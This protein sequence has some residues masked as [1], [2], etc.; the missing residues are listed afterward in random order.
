[1]LG[2]AAFLGLRTWHIALRSQPKTYYD[3]RRGR[4]LREILHPHPRHSPRSAHDADA[5][6]RTV[7]RCPSRLVPHR[8]SPRVV[9]VSVVAQ[10]LHPATPITSGRPTTDGS[11]IA[12]PWLSHTQG[13]ID[14]AVHQPS[15]ARAARTPPVPTRARGAIRREE[16][17]AGVGVRW[18]DGRL[19][20][21]SVQFRPRSLG[22]QQLFAL[23]P[24]DAVQERLAGLGRAR[25]ACQTRCEGGVGGL[26]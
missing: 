24:V 12:P 25:R 8:R 11:D 17:Y 2:S 22:R 21:E 5:R 13:G 4:P 14:P 7:H 23:S 1:M 10:Q 18:V 16:L 9:S 19:V 20:P 15:L 6:A 3:I 26:V